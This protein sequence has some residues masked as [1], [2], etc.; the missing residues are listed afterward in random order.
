MYRC[1]QL[2]T[3]GKGA[4]SPNPMVGAVVVHNNKIIGEGYHRQYG[5]AHAEV[6]AIASVK[7]KS[8]LKD[9][10][11]YVS[12]EPCSH[13]GKT[14]PCAKL[15]IDSGIPNVIVGCLDPYP[16]VSGR[17]IRMLKE[18]GVNTTVGILEKECIQL[19]KE[20]NCVQQKGKPYIYLKW[21][22]SK[23]G[24]IDK[25][26]DSH[27]VTPSSISNDF[28]KILVH[29]LRSEVDAIM[30]G[31]NTA[32]LDNPSLTTRLWYGKSPIRIILDRQLKIDLNHRIFDQS[33]PTLIFTEKDKGNH[34]LTNVEFIKTDF[35]NNSLFQFLFKTLATRG[36]NSIMI[37]GGAKLL[38]SVIDERL[39]DE[40]VVE[41]SDNNFREGVEAPNIEGI[42]LK[43]T[44]WR[45]SEQIHFLNDQIKKL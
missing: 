35:N 32:I 8:L 23:D 38:Q 5:E 1:L 43:K 36:I 27:K 31:T 14:P 45:E 40:A 28:T 30:I 44:R 16:K 7:D 25:I 3:K 21:A 12:L 6:N 18:A 2:A 4:V 34:T 22:Q 10:T 37:E 24:F 15:I 20:F 26:R 39:W 11:L 17:G 13:Y 42:V 9:S 29:K 33:T 19:N 41:I